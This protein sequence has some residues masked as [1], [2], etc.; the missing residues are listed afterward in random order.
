MYLM[1]M[2]VTVTLYCTINI[3]VNTEH[4]AVFI[5]TKYEGYASGVIRLTNQGIVYR[6]GIF[7]NTSPL[8]TVDNKLEKS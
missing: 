6:Q 8:F 5:I 3:Y 2:T 4:V 7:T 1:Y